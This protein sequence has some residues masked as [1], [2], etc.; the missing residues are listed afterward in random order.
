MSAERIK[1][2]REAFE[3]ARQ[4]LEGAGNLLQNIPDGDSEDSE[5]TKEE[6][7]D[8]HDKTCICERCTH[9]G[10][11]FY[12]MRLEEAQLL[13]L[14]DKLRWRQERQRINSKEI[15]QTLIHKE[16]IERFRILRDAA[17]E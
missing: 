2:F 9:M 13:F 5:D 7:E 6:S 3:E 4:A 16:A 17:K 15:N 1:F 14:S 8:I 11:E 12:D 10:K